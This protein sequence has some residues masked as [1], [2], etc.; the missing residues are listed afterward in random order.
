[1]F[2]LES[3]ATTTKTSIAYYFIPYACIKEGNVIR[4]CHAGV[5]SFD[6]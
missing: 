4:Q 3:T 6:W 2:L 1:M 5:N